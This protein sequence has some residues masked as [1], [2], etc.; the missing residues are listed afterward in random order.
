MGAKS[1][2]CGSPQV[3]TVLLSASESADG[4][5]VAGEVGNAGEGLAQLLVE[6]DGG[7]V[8]L[9]EFVFQGARFFHDGRGFVVLAGLLERAYLLAELVAAS[10]ALLGK[11]DG[12]AAA[13]IESAKIAQQSCGVSATGAQLFFNQL[14]VGADELQIEHISFILDEQC[15]KLARRKEIAGPRMR[16]CVAR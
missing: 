6:I 1:N 7:V 13:L 2:F 5:F 11:S 16:G 10:F 8:E 14:Q 3:L 4:N 15:R 9:V 12:F